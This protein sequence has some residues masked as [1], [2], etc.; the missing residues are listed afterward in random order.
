MIVLSVRVNNKQYGFGPRP[1]VNGADG[2]PSLLS[3][4]RCGPTGEA[5]FVLEDQGRQFKC[6]FLVFLLVAQ[7]LGFVQFVPHCVYTYCILRVS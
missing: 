4:R 3:R 2:V 7:V 1:N 5:A 6:D